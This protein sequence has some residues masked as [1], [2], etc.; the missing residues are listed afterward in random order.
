MRRSATKINC[1]LTSAGEAKETLAV[2]DEL[3]IQEKW[4]CCCSNFPWFNIF[5]TSWI[6]FSFVSG[7]VNEYKTKKNKNQT[8]L[9]NPKPRKM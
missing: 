8:G 1:L 9:K 2:M 4:L 3:P 7:Y 5:Q 6:L